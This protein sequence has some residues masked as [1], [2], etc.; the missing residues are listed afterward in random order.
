MLLQTDNTLNFERKTIGKDRRMD[1]YQLKSFLWRC[2]GK[3][4]QKCPKRNVNAV[5]DSSLMSDSKYHVCKAWYYSV[6]Q[7]Y[8]R[9]AFE[10]C[11]KGHGQTLILMHIRSKDNGDGGPPRGTMIWGNRASFCASVCLYVLITLSL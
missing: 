7:T 10:Q 8:K 2:Y 4:K 1:A 11:K 3:K 9:I 6:R 5:T